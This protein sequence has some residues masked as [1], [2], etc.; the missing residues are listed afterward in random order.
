MSTYSNF[1]KGSEWRKWDLHIHSNASD[2]SS[3]PTEI[4]EEASNKRIDVI[5]LTDHHTVKNID[6]T[7][8]LGEKKGIKVISGI[9][10]RTEYGSS[11]VHMIGLFPDFYNG[12]KID[13][14]FLH[15]QILCLLNLSDINI[16][17]KG[18]NGELFDDD[19]SVFK[20]GMFLV[21]VEFKKAADLIHK[22]G[23]LV[24]VHAGSKS[25]S[26]E[27]MKHLGTSSRNVRE[28]YDSLGTVKEELLKDYVDICEIRKENDSQSFYY[29]KF[30][31]PSII[32]SDA[33]KKLEIGSKY[34]WIKADATFEGLKQIIYE[35]DG[36]VIIQETN[37]NTKKMYNI[38]EK[39][40]FIDNSGKNKFTNFEI[41]LNPDLNA[42][43]GGKSSGKSLLLHSMAK[44][45]GYKSAN[46]D[47]EKILENIQLE[48]YYADEP[49]RKRTPEDRRIIEFLPQLHIEQIVREKSEKAKASDSQNYFDSF[50]ENLI[51]QEDEIK[52]LYETHLTLINDAQE[53]LNDNITTWITL[54]KQLSIAMDE[55]K[56]LG[57][58]KA[59]LKEIKK[60]EE[61]I[62]NLKIKSGLSDNEIQLFNLLTNS[63]NECKLKI[64]QL[65][66]HKS[67]IKNMRDYLAGFFF[68]GVSSFLN[69]E[70]DDSYT[71]YLFGILFSNIEKSL[72]KEGNIFF[73]LVNKK[74]KKIEYILSFL[75]KKIDKNNK[76]L[77]P[78]LTKN[79]IKDDIDSMESN[80]KT[81]KSKIETII[82]KENEIVEIK[83]RRD[84][85]KFIS[86]Y[87]KIII[88]YK[89]LATAINKSIGEK[90]IAGNRN[91]TLTA[92]PIFEVSK[93]TD[94]IASVIN[95]QTYLENQ[96]PN[97]GFSASDY[98]YS[99]NHIHNIENILSNI[100]NDEKRFQNFK[101][102]GNIEELLRAVLKNCNYIDFDIIKD[103]DSLQ[104]MSEGKKGI[105]VLQLYLS[106]S[107]SDCPILIDQPEDNLDN[108]TVYIELNDYI[109]QCK[110]RRQIIMV[111]HNA[112]LVVNTD[113]ENVIVAN[114]DGEDGKDNKEYK[115]EYV[116]GAL[117]NTFINSNEKG[118][119][120]QKG[121][122]E[123]VCEILEG[124]MDAFKKREEKYNLHEK[125][126][127][128]KNSRGNKQKNA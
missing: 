70:T 123:H 80:A 104:D 36:R 15:D 53:R 124:G 32:A 116:N 103:G 67:E 58:K 31:L 85:I 81:E 14:K 18:N 22:Y 78:I 25:D 50:I 42:I 1:S 118:V 128:I 20:K 65:E 119:L 44:T 9:E 74:E 2:G 51:Q 29:E 86:D 96:F 10:F 57:D 16:I 121:I 89:E 8:Q 82:L 109:K 4:I 28:L 77:I 52:K 107:K 55:L 105:V 63:N 73:E 127:K 100:I 97:C 120:Y 3:S 48:V 110:Q 13:S 87:E 11:S 43:I 91:L 64:T 12:I 72:E 71:Q 30:G 41:G 83:K 56:P 45:I 75:N 33:H 37:P 5:A 125:Y 113:A 17:S 93:F 46:K 90:W 35:P 24:S 59:I 7:K 101:K 23:G 111:S 106:L 47:Y 61:N 49:D 84:E 94:A 99:D 117:E 126:G 38:I 40:K 26:I 79:K 114:Q 102:S 54:D 95:M 60:I 19:E 69:F 6:E 27:N 76:K 115:F 66:K 21:Q 98:K 34:V 92:T 112:N 68:D 39:V 88:L 122:K 108:R 62:E